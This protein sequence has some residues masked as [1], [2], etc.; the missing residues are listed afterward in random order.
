MSDSTNVKGLIPG[1]YEHAKLD[2][3]NPQAP[4]EIDVNMVLAE[5]GTDPEQGLSDKVAEE[6]LS[7]HPKKMHTKYQRRNWA[8]DV[9]TVIRSGKEKKVSPMQL[10]VGDIISFMMGEKFYADGIIIEPA[11]PGVRV[12]QS[13]LTGETQPITKDPTGTTKG[14][15]Q[16]W[17]GTFAIEGKGRMVALQ[18][19]IHTA[20]GKVDVHAH[21]GNKSSGCHLL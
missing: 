12:D 8:M 4:F 5:I 21:C 2:L 14:H 9:V 16:L 1:S 17:A 6:R 20:L 15:H 11:Q 13:F 18:L 19:G 3:S 10:V 7:R